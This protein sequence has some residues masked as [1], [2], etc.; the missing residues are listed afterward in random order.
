LS[1]EEIARILN[2]PVGTV[3]SR[4]FRARKELKE[5]LLKEDGNYAM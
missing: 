5:R 3:E 2:C 4:L 1:Y